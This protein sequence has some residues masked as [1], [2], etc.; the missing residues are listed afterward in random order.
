MEEKEVNKMKTGRT[1]HEFIV[2]V[3]NAGSFRRAELA[4]LAAL[5]SRW[6]D[7]CMFHLRRLTKPKT[8]EKPN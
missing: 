2:V 7:G 3:K 5:A 8:N 4:I 1:D 6:P